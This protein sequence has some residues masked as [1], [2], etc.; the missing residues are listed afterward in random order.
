MNR[1]FGG[2]CVVWGGAILYGY[3]I[4]EGAPS[5]GSDAYAT[6]S[7]VGV[8]FGGLMFVAGL[9]ALFRRESP[10]EAGHCNA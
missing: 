2:I 1:I 6:G 8:A 4:D 9:F 3:F 5:L 10:R 7:K